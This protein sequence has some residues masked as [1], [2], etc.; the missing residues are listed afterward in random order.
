M[1]DALP[2]AAWMTRGDGVIRKTNPAFVRLYGREVAT[3]RALWPPD[4]APPPQA[5][6]AFVAWNGRV[7]HQLADGR[8]GLVELTRVAIEGGWVVTYAVDRSGE[9][10]A[11]NALAA[12]QEALRRAQD[13][14]QRERTLD[15]VTGALQAR[16]LH[17]QLRV[18]IERCRRYARP[19]SLLAVQVEHL[20][21]HTAR[22]GQVG[23]DALLTL[24][25]Q[26][27]RDGRR[28]ADYLGRLDGGLFALVLPETPL[29]NA[30]PLAEGL[31]RQIEGRRAS[32]G[33]AS[34]VEV[35]VALRVSV[36]AAG[37]PGTASDPDTLIAEATRGL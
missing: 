21:T 5:L 28:S 27:L 2:V 34:G 22:L 16:E 17:R 8:I 11:R 9:A 7:A 31:R 24:V 14:L 10:D 20:D 13:E 23:V 18:E 29:A 35:A 30:R 26:G 33:T 12:T 4:T 32:V 1:F 36:S 37:L 6:G 19:L 25:A 3:E 15:L